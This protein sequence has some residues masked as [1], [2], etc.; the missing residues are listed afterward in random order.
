MILKYL[1]Q[2]GIWVH[3]AGQSEKSV[4]V[5]VPRFQE[6]L[7]ATKSPK[8]V[9]CKIF[10]N[11]NNK[12]IQDL[13]NEV[14]HNLVCLTLKDLSNNITVQMNKESEKWYDIYKVLYNDHLK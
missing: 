11:R 6:L 14:N 13:R 10:F 3:K 7:S 5:G 12:T 1:D 8:I 4:T 2:H 9:N